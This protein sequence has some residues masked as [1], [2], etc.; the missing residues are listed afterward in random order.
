M[1]K[2]P[3]TTLETSS[4]VPRSLEH[5]PPRKRKPYESP[6]LQEWG[7]ILELTKGPLSG[8]VD[9]DFSGSGGV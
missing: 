8:T 2:H 9:G 1:T 4:V 6:C 7:S 3:E 5:A